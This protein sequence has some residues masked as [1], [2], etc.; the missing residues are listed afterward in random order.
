MFLFQIQQM[1]GWI[2]VYRKLADSKMWLSEPFTRGQA[3]IDLIILANHKDGFFRVRGVRVDIK[4][5][6][7][8]HTAANLAVRWM[9]SKGKV[10]RFLNELENDSQIETQKTNVTTLISILNYNE[11]QTYGTQNETQTDTQTERRRNA[12][13]TQTDP[14]NN[15]KNDKKNNKESTN[16]DKKNAAK[17]ATLSRKEE[18]YKSL[19][20]FVDK[21]PK[22]MIRAFFDYWSEMNKSETKMKFE[23]QSTWEVGKRLATWANK[24]TFNGKQNRAKTNCDSSERKQSVRN[25]TDLSEAILQGSVP[26]KP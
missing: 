19:I 2:K 9:W 11:Y 5:G 16:V 4:R 3:W 1:E 25:L 22:D 8:G 13:G 6:Q 17:A 7:V 15:D 23:M 12:D 21:Y 26:Q 14:N 10:L 20:P 18:F 24:E